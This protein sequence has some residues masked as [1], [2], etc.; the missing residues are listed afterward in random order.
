MK[1]L[2][3]L[4]ICCIALLGCSTTIDSAM[5]EGKWYINSIDGIAYQEQLNFHDCASYEFKKDGG[6]VTFNP[7]VKTTGKWKIV[8]RQLRIIMNL[9][10]GRMETTE[11]LIKSLDEKELVLVI[12]QDENSLSL[13]KTCISRIDDE[14]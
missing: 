10:D 1:I 13:S 8:D 2:I 14:Y 9:L 11:Y 7:E 4:G 6:V 5:L 3:L 12:D